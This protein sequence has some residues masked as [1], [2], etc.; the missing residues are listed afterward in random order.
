[1]RDRWK[2]LALPLLLL[3]IGIVLIVL[4]P[5]MLFVSPEGVDDWHEIGRSLERFE[6]NFGPRMIAYALL[7]LFTAVSSVVVYHHIIWQ[8][9]LKQG[10]PSGYGL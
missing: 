9:E 8:R 1:M 3:L 5:S 4:M 6:V 2:T 7:V 10:D